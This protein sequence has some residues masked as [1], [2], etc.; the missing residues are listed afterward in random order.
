[1]A[2]KIG[3]Y[4]LFII[5]FITYLNLFVL[6]YHQFTEFKFEENRNTRKLNKKV[7]F[8]T[9]F[10]I[11][12]AD[13][14]HLFLSSYPGILTP[15]SIDQVN[16]ILNWKFNNHHPFYHTI[17]MAAF[18]KTGL[19]ILGNIN[20]A[21][22]FYSAFQ[23]I[24]MSAIFAFVV[25]TLY[26][27]KVSS[28]VY[29]VIAFLY[30]TLP[31]HWMFSCTLWKNVPFSGMTAI[32]I[33]SYYRWRKGIG[34]SNLNLCLFAISSL[35]MALL[36][37]N[38]IYAYAIFAFVLL[39]KS[40]WETTDRKP[41]FLALVAVIFSVVLQGPVLNSI[42]V[43]KDSFSSAV[44]IPLQQMARVTLDHKNLSESDKMLIN[45]YM[46]VSL[47]PKRYKWFIS[48]PIKGLAWQREVANI[49]NK[50]FKRNFIKDWLKLGL[51]YP[52]SYAK[53]W[54]DQTKGYWNGSYQ[55]WVAAHGVNQNQI[56]LQAHPVIQKLSDL[57]GKIAHNLHY[58]S[59]GNLITATGFFSSALLLLFL[60]NLIRYK[61][62]LSE[63][64]VVFSII[65]SLLASTPV[66]NEFRYIYSL[67]TSLPFLIVIGLMKEGNKDE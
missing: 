58:G 37:S 50:Q 65:I 27:M 24:M 5:T 41:A 25:M 11:M 21:V 13:L 19:Y 46:D 9:F 23:C 47:A 8:Y 7:F 2:G 62:F 42:G 34:N 31:Y 40:I 16:Q 54:V 55:Y 66:F 33:V 67:Y 39:A 48:D 63:Y 61:R 10:I 26:E 4:R 64:L 43:G 6:A 59:F 60:F 12:A 36:Q 15:D 22:A 29:V 32:V 1:M 35:M 45:R 56:G 30:A 3:A 57:N 52:K 14:L 28:K 20:A 49:N 18:I 44:S 17:I 38:G 51:K 53:A